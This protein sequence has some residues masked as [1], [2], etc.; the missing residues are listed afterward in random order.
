[1]IMI[2]IDNR[3]R[4]RCLEKLGAPIQRHLFKSS[5][6]TMDLRAATSSYAL[7][8]GGLQGCADCYW[9]NVAG[10]LIHIFA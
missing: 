10:G 6:S 5:R 7:R 3:M 8:K 1:M 9:A 2:K 4:G